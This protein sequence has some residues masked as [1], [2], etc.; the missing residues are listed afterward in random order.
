MIT[1]GLTR[2]DAS[3]SVWQRSERFATMRAAQRKAY[4]LRGDADHMAGVPAMFG[5]QEI[6]AVRQEAAQWEHLATWLG[7][8]VRTA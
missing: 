2:T 4:N 6:S 8:S 1:L 7:Q 5:P 3:L